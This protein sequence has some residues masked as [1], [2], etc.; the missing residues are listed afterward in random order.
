MNRT[1]LAALFVALA[2]SSACSKPDQEKTNEKTAEAREKVRQAAERAS[3][4]ARKLGRQVK[5]DASSLS[6]NLDRAMNRPGTTARAEEKLRKGAQDLRTAGEQARVKLDQAAIIAQVKSK[7][8]S[9]LGLSTMTDIDVYANDGVVTLKG[10]VTSPDLK[11]QAAE[12]A[13][14]IDGVSR[15]VN[16]LVVKP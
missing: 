16:Q 6:R 7:L 13:R 9:D 10:S 15:V 3:E 12:A 14:K 4:D 5:D 1:C 8:A 2:W 11:D